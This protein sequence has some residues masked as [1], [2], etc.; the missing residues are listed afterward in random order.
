MQN[1]GLA[2]TLAATNFALNPLATLV[3]AIF[4]VCHNIS[5]AIFATLR[6]ENSLH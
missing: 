6:R 4:S 2:V 3:G 5:G 1:S